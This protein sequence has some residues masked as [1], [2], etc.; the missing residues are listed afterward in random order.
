MF[1]PEVGAKLTVQLPSELVR[2][3]VRAVPDPDSAI[4]EII[5]APLRG[6]VH[7]YRKGDLVAVRRKTSPLGPIVWES[8]DEAKLR[9]EQA[10]KKIEAEKA[11][12][13][14]APAPKAKPPKAKPKK[15][16]TKRAPRAG[17][18]PRDGQ[19][20][21]PRADRKRKTAK[22][23]GRDRAVKRATPSAR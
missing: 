7:R 3:E 14:A 6:S 8:I 1:I 5:V 23:G 20:K 4:V 16:E 22:A 10:V 17:K 15:K 13:Q 18:R 12:A 2:A 9:L 19:S 11:Q 21:H